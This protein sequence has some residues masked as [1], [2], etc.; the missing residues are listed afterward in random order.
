MHDDVDKDVYDDNTFYPKLIQDLESA[1]GLVL[2]QSP[3]LAINRIERL[4][5][6]MVKLIRRGVRVCT[7]VRLP[8]N[9]NSPNI[10]AQEEMARIRGDARVLQDMGV[11]VNL[12]PHKHEKVL[13]IDDHLL[14]DGSLNTFSQN[15]SSER[16]TRFPV[17]YKA[18]AAIKSLELYRCDQCTAQRPLTAFHDDDELLQQYIGR[19]VCKQRKLLS[20]SQCLLGKIAGVPEKTIVE[21]EKGTRNIEVKTLIRVCR[22]LGLEL[23]LADWFLTPVIQRFI[24]KPLKH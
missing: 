6:P 5:E 7:F 8:D 24:D 15:R 1:R 3:Y 18:I 20:L 12:R 10:Q 17:R 9:W 4:R 13:T 11:H 2:I 23:M 19:Q 22:V 16:M 14:Y 21:L